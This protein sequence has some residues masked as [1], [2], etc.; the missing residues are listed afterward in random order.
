MAVL[1]LASVGAMAQASDRQ[2]REI[3]DE[4]D[5]GLA[6]L[7]LFGDGI[8]AHREAVLAWRRTHD[9]RGR[10]K[11]LPR[12]A[13]EVA[14]V[15]QT[16]HSDPSSAKAVSSLPSKTN[17]VLPGLPT[18]LIAVVEGAKPVPGAPASVPNRLVAEPPGGAATPGAAPVSLAAIVIDDGQSATH[19]LLLPLETDGGA[20][21]F[22]S[23]EDV[24]VV[25]DTRRPFDLSAV[26]GDPLG[27][28]STVQLLASA[29]IVRFPGRRPNQLGLRRVAAGWLV[30]AAPPLPEPASI[31][32]S[33]DVNGLKLPLAHPG[34][35]VVVPNPL[36]GGNLLVGT[37][38]DGEDAMRETRHGSSA[39][40]DR[41]ILGVVVEPLSDR[42]ELQPTPGG[43][44]LAGV[45]AS[46]LNAAM[47]AGRGAAALRVMALEPASPVLLSTRF[48]QA[49]A[50]AA[51]APAEARFV[52]R[53]RAAEDALAL[54]DGQDAA[55]IIKVARADDPR[56]ANAL[57]PRLV[58]SAA[59]ALDGKSDP[60]GLLDD[61]T[62][63]PL[64]EPG[65]WRAVRLARESPTSS[66]AARLFAANLP[67]LEAYPLPLRTILL[68]LAAETLVRAGTDTQAGLVGH[69]PDDVSLS[70]ARALLSARQG[71]PKVA[72]AALDRL[73]ASSDWV[74]GD[75]A[76][77]AASTI[78]EK[79]PKADLKALADALDARLLDARIGGH[80]AESRLHLADLRM[81]AGQWEKALDLLRE[82]ARLYPA[83]QAEARRR[84]GEV[85]KR[86]SAVSPAAAE[87][88]ALDQAAMIEANA[89]MLPG[90][91][92]GTRVSLF[93][94][95][96]LETLDLPER[97]SPIVRNMMN[98]AAPGPDRAELGLKLAGLDYQQN[99]LPAV[100]AA[101]EASDMPGLPAPIAHARAI[102]MARALAAE[103]NIKQALSV[104]QPIDG[105]PALDLR[106][107][108]LARTQDWAG[109]TDCLLELARRR[110]PSTGK[111]SPSDQDLLLRLASA[112]S[113]TNDPA[114]LKLVRGLGDGRVA[115]AGKAALFKLLTSDP[116]ADGANP[117]AGAAEMMALRHASGILDSVAR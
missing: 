106:A 29:T 79:Q 113:R 46:A 21:A 81:Q 31:K 95:S 37:V 9:M 7:D 11:R 98:A 92:E 87:G 71:H 30:Q 14:K 114:R 10:G 88:Q 6:L 69:L 23:G 75:K 56:Q 54:G 78:R 25:L 65:L 58:A 97:A 104:L 42:L 47:G 117:G 99:N 5:A 85:L 20:A 61:P 15:T 76:A 33:P 110:L 62:I 19:G 18:S 45:P 107:G 108:F 74:V 44:L 39:V 103:G 83:T 40:L 53:L 51:E 80:E 24:L 17:S 32:P 27:A 101:L 72:L 1:T 48:T 22:A 70:F 89:D 55:T 36:T 82:T 100:L 84:V 34:Q 12:R 96:R 73:G 16:R 59:A 68:P 35:S 64:G 94:A 3:Q 8:L 111:L 115:D 49:R 116:G 90:G 43:F 13:L 66:E 57:R 102:M 26:Q 38:R 109:S 52:P 77:E 93:L 112:A 4:R 41:T 105:E 28:G 50:D 91:S 60:S 67:L 86:L 63:A 2:T